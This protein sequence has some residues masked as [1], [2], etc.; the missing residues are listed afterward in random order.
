MTTT[1]RTRR[2]YDTADLSCE[3]FWAATAADR[4]RVFVE[5]RSER[6]VS[7]RRP[8]ENGLLDQLGRPGVLGR[9]PA[10][11]PRRGDQAAR[12]LHLRAGHRLR[13]DT[14]GAARR[15]AGVHR[16]GPPAPHPAPTAAGLRV[17]APADGPCRRPDRGQRAPGRGR[18]RRARS[19]RRRRRTRSP[20]PDAQHLRH[21][22]CPRAA[23][24]GG[25]PRSAVRRRVARPGPAAG[26]RARGTALPVRRSAP[27][28]RHRAD[29][30]PPAPRRPPPTTC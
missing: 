25:R 19:H 22:G 24:A 16:H 12:G 10:C 5:L 4:E 23:P 3:G 15:R 18:H 13:L 7:W 28:G 29:R 2:A 8:A 9:R 21:D 26:R 11:R 14:A 30:P 17:H 20:H 27:R 1:T 6:P